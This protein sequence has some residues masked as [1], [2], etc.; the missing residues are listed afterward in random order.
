MR[1]AAGGLAALGLPLGG[2]TLRPSL[3]DNADYRSALRSALADEGF[4]AAYARRGYAPL[5]LGP[6]G[7][8]NAAGL[9]ALSAVQRAGDH[10]LS[11]DGMDAPRHLAASAEAAP[12]AAGRL[13]GALSAAIGRLAAAL[14]TPQPG[15]DLLWTDPKLRPPRPAPAAVIQDI[16]AARDSA[17]RMAEILSIHPLS[18]GLADRM[19]RL[20]NRERG[21]ARQ[22]I[23]SPGTRGA[24]VQAVRRNLARLRALPAL[25]GP[26]HIIVNIPAAALYVYE[27][28]RV[29]KAMRAVVGAPATPTPMMAGSIT[30]AVL[31]PY[32][33]IPQDLLRARIAPAIL[34]GG[35]AAFEK[36]R[37]EALSDWSE[38]ARSLDPAGIDWAAVA[39]GNLRLRVR[40]KPGADNMMGKVKFMLPNDLG[41]YLHDTPDKALFAR[42]DRALSAGC[43]RVEHPHDLFYWLFG[44]SLEGMVDGAAEQIVSLGR[45]VPVFLIYQTMS[46]SAGGAA[47]TWP[48]I[49][50]YDRRE[51]SV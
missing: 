19:R 35:V 48:D 22:D 27:D 2:A 14:H 32:W 17:A 20:R 42:N 40:Q 45:S 34:K 38:G 31:N 46:I 13:E 44:R 4:E 6:G 29:V 39:A 43:V 51:Q 28:R 30:H 9:R 49:Y 37:L 18:A 41:I 33:N 15:Q 26:R 36:R 50:G 5:W 25:P 10:G 16:A 1:V 23:S 21:Q 11:Q 7:A 24:E 3:A 8:L 47:E 12:A